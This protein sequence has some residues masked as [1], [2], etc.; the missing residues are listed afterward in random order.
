MRKVASQYCHTVQL[1]KCFELAHE[2]MGA[3][4][5]FLSS[6][7]KES[8][9]DAKHGERYQDF[10]KQAEDTILRK[11]VANRAYL[12]LV[13]WRKA[14]ADLVNG[15]ASLSGVEFLQKEWSEDRLFEI[16]ALCEVLRGAKRRGIGIRPWSAL[17]Q[18]RGRPL[19]YLEESPLYYNSALQIEDSEETV[20]ELR[21]QYLRGTRPDMFV[22]NTSDLKSSIVVDMK[23]YRE[24][25]VEAHQKILMYM[26][27]YDV[28]NGA[29]IYPIKL[30]ARDLGLVNVVEKSATYVR[31]STATG[32]F[33]AMTLTPGKISELENDAV[34]NR[35][36]DFL[37]STC[38]A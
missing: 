22:V 30:D 25:S 32:S 17:F 11:R 20:P 33:V 35:F 8:M 21:R 10:S 15:F 5:N 36:A 3:E 24:T 28:N 4:R 7:L 6:R 13:S 19:F 26:K 27:N 23:N 14:Y 37:I 29:V 1:K 31:S 16:W 38:L 9:Q 2:F 18:K 12:Q 34:V